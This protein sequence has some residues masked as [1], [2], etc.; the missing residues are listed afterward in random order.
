M[1]LEERVD[2]VESWL[3]EVEDDLGDLVRPVEIGLA[4]AGQTFQACEAKKIA[5]KWA[6]RRSRRDLTWAFFEVLPS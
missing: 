4:R 5:H 2:E 3:L 6:Y 1:T